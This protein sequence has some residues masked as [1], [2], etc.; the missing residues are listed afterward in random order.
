[1]AQ[2]KE[3]TPEETAALAAA[4]ANAGKAATAVSEAATQAAQSFAAKAAAAQAQAMKRNE[5]L[6][7][8]RIIA[9]SFLQ[10]Y[11]LWIAGGIGAYVLFFRDKGKR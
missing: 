6:A 2:L 3:Y 5:D 9:P 8:G 10:K 7:T 11:G 4:A 1:M